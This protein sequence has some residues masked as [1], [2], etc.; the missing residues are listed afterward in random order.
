MQPC[1]P[2]AELERLLA[3]QMSDAERAALEKH[4]EECAACQEALE[5]LT[6][7]RDVEG[8]Q[9]LHQDQDGTESPPAEDF[10]RRLRETPPPADRPGGRPGSGPATPPEDG[11][12]AGGDDSPSQASPPAPAWRRRRGR[13][14]GGCGW[15]ATRCWGRRAGPA[16][17]S[18][19]A[20]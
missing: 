13:P 5:G 8:W 1:P 10:L 7:S 2:R 15:S 18:S 12:P 14:P 11:P 16:W 3:R 19:T 6:R 17:A 20:T 9:R 4:V